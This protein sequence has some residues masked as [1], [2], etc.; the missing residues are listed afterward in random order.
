[1]PLFNKGRS[2]RQ[3]AFSALVLVVVLAS[4]AKAHQE[5]ETPAAPPSEAAVEERQPIAESDV[6]SRADTVT[7]DLRRVEE[8]L[9]PQTAIFRIEELLDAREARI[10]D[11]LADLDRI[12]RAR[13][14][15]RRLSDQRVPWEELGDEL[16]H[17]GKRVEDRYSALQIQRERMRDERELWQATRQTALGDELAPELQR[18]IEAILT[19][20]GE[21][22]S[23]VRKRRNEVGAID[24]RI[25]NTAEV[26]ID[27]LAR[28][29]AVSDRL[30]GNLL[31]RNAEP[32][33][34]AQARGSLASWSGDLRSGMK[35]WV[36]SF[37]EYMNLRSGSLFGMLA[38]FV[39]LL[40]VTLRLRHSARRRTVE[41]GRSERAYALS[42][43]PISLALLFLV[44][45]ATLLMVPASTPA[46]LVFLLTC[47]VLIRLG[48]IVLS[49]PLQGAVIGLCTLT[50]L[51]RI[52]SLAPDGSGLDRLLLTAV[53]LVAF[54]ATAAW[55]LP[56][57]AAG[58]G[59][60]GLEHALI[61]I[62]PLAV[63]L[64]GVALVAGILGWL[65]LARILTYATVLSALSGFGWAV[66]IAS[67]TALLSWSIAGRLGDVL[68]SLRREQPVIERTTLIVLI[69]FV[70][71]RWGNRTLDLLE[72][73]KL[74][75]DSV[76]RVAAAHLGI[77]DL[78]LSVG[79]LVSAVVVIVLTVFV[80]RLV[81][82]VLSEE[83]A[84]RFRIDTGAAESVITLTSYVVY[85]TGIA[86]A[87]SAAGLSG[88]Q[89][90]VVIGALSVGIGFGLQNI[91][92]NFVSGLILMFER[93]IKV[94]DTVQ[95][96]D[97]S[98]IV[99][100]IGIRAS[101]IRSFSGAEIAVPNADLISKEVVNW[102]R[103]DKIRRIEVPIGVAYGTDP[104]KVLDILLRL[105]KEHPFTLETPEP[106]AQMLGYGDSSMNFRVR[107]WTHIE[108]WIQVSSDV[109]VA[110]N[111]AF[112]EA[113]VTIPFPQRDLHLKSIEPDASAALGARGD[114]TPQ[115]AR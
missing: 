35:Y 15:S 93:P 98:G 42:E 45:V 89:V 108:H 66:L 101:T 25:A 96:T 26:V 32:L 39:A 5:D 56:R 84:P 72:V 33:W 107:L 86:F 69:A 78:E 10:V 82:F 92:S 102:T 80:V 9:Q 109:N 44:L 19:R 37:R 8:F 95:T 64:T 76:A 74:A 51:V 31:Q 20:I 61:V 43:R 67:V 23:L 79:G 103:S 100:R 70:L 1:M 59:L 28:L 30:R 4:G 106:D 34:S 48:S 75:R 115:A 111:A 21:V 12:S 68:P 73:K 81:R 60:P 24:N 29:S 77:G 65:D 94:G 11:L 62:A 112:S 114:D 38:F 58:R 88:T 85:G 18:R 53:S 90:T 105:A 99:T 57:R 49:A 63:V 16:A 7:A 54:V 110:I 27:S 83:V 17:W 3:T 22:E 13:M 87:A 36:G 47:V 52:T 97:N 55:V 40:V 14:S 41:K 50:V 91:V 113:G 2:A 71:L 104:Q 46:D 6:P